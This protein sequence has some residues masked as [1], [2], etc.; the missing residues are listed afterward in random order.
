MKTLF[1]IVA[2]FFSF[3]A[4]SQTLSFA[5]LVHL[6]SRKDAEKFL[7]SKSFTS[8]RAPAYNG[9]NLE[10]VINSRTENEE[11][12]DIS[13][14]SGIAYMT[15]NPDYVKFLLNQI[16]TK[17][18]K[19]SGFDEPNF[20]FYQFGDPNFLITVNLEKGKTR[21]SIAIEWK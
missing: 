18:H 3:N 8:L 19:V 13:G 2:V 5:E 20:K 21:H 4:Y 9:K 16:K 6:H 15:R 7:I 17:Y 14:Q 1:T 11:E 12:I 10:Y